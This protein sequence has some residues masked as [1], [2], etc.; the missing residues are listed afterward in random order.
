MSQ[1]DDK[2]DKSEDEFILR[3]LG[4]FCLFPQK[5]LKRVEKDDVMKVFNESVAKVLEIAPHLR[6]NLLRYFIDVAFADGNLD[7]KEVA[8]IYD[9]GDK[10]GFPQGEIAKALGIKIREDFCPKASALK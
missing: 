6:S 8:L 5:E 9:F 4:A 2:R 10:L 1:L 3:Q 7:E